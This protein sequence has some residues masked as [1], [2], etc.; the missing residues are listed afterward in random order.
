MSWRAGVSP[1]EIGVAAVVG[2]GG[3]FY[4]FGPAAE[5]LKKRQESILAEREKLQAQQPAPQPGLPGGGWPVPAPPL[6][7]GGSKRSE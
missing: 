3:G 2:I 1:L 5:E 6:P 7:D 4:V